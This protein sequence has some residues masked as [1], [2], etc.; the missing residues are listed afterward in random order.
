MTE[1]SEGIGK[2]SSWKWSLAVAWVAQFLCL[3]GF[4]AFFPFI[5]FYVRDLGVTDPDHVKIWSGIIMSTTAAAM[6]LVSPLWGLLADRKGTKLMVL[7]AAFGGAVTLVAMAL[8][9]NVQQFFVLRVVQGA[10][11]GFNLA[12][13]ML[14]SSF[15]PSSRIGSALGMMQMGAYLAFSAGPLLGGVLADYVGYRLTCVFAAGA[16][17]LGGLLVVFLLPDSTTQRS[18]GTG[19]LRAGLRAIT[20]SSA[21]GRVLV[22]VGAIYLANSL[23]RPVLPLFVESLMSDLAKVNTGTGALYGAMSFASA[24]SAVWIGRLGDRVGYQRIVLVC[25]A[26]VALAY[27]AQALSPSFTWLVMATLV[28]GFFIG[29]LLPTT[30]AIIARTAPKEVQGTVYGLSNSISS[31]GRMFGPAMGAG[32][33]AAWGMRYTFALAGFVFGMVAFWLFRDERFRPESRS[34]SNGEV[35]K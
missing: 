34:D 26:G 19:N 24:I 27:G 12:F 1:Q 14:V 7:R 31:V 28:T 10:L 9:Q 25:A 16:L 35:M 15:V 29:G 11:T 18:A 22:I 4:D 23:S 32:V 2:R 8:A 6:T 30:N 33:A 13:V 5:P 21:V 20:Q 3:V 17:L